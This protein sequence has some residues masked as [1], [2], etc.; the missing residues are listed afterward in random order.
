MNSFDFKNPG[1]ATFGNQVWIGIATIHLRS[2]KSRSES[3]N[4]FLPGGFAHCLQV[5]IACY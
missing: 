2:I 5:D 1:D 3:S 4:A